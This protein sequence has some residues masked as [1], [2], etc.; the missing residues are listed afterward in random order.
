M[1][2]AIVDE[3][4]GYELKRAQ[5]VLRLAMDRD[6][7]PL[8]LTTPQYAALAMLE[9]ERGLSGAELAR[10]AFVSAQTMNAIVS[11]LE[12]RDLI[13]RGARPDHGRILETRLT[14]QGLALVRSA[15]GRV[16]AIEAKMTGG[17]NE[18][19]QRELLR[20]LRT[21]RTALESKAPAERAI[22]TSRRRQPR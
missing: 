19:E 3:R 12:E 7:R 11:S 5:Q 21:C 6:L 22:Q 4:V 10:R 20:L 13:E 9:E 8:G 17:L 14:R 2:G 15:H 18:G 16:R 1:I